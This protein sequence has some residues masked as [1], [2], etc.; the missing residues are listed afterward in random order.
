MPVRMTGTIFSSCLRR[1]SMVTLPLP[2]PVA[3]SLSGVASPSVLGFYP[4]PG[5]ESTVI[6]SCGLLLLSFS[7]L[8]VLGEGVLSL[9]SRDGDLDGDRTFLFLSA[10]FLVALW[11]AS[12]VWRT[13]LVAARSTAVQNPTS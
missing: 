13:S 5:G 1:A 12:L 8:G 4:G 6:S 10:S 9:L 2:A 11:K 3:H 7:P